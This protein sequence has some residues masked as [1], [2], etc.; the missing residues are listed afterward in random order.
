MSGR[1]QTTIVGIF[2]L[3]GIGVMCTLVFMFGGGR[4]F[5]SS[6]YD[7]NIHFDKGLV[8][9]QTG[10]GVTMYGKRIGETRAVDFW[11]PQKM[12]EGVK[13][14]VA[15]DGKYEIPALSQATVVS[16]IMGIGRPTVQIEVIDPRDAT[17]LPRDG[18]GTIMG[19]MV[20]PL[21]QVL[22][23]NMLR[24]I[25]Q[26]TEDIGALAKALQPVAQN[27]DRLLESRDIKQVDLQ[28][29]AANLDTVIQRF[30]LVLKNVNTVLGD[31]QNQANLRE[32]LANARKMSETGTAVMD[33]LKSMSEDGMVTMK[34]ADALA[35]KLISTADDMS[36]VLKRMDQTIAMLNDKQGSL[37][38]MLN[39]NRLY[40]E[41]VLSARRLTTM[42]DDMREVLDQ[43][44]QG[45]LRIK[46]F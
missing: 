39:D 29:V 45:K 43:V 9:V 21:D 11:N 3:A 42:L 7:I 37:G 17:K 20:Q 15:I 26:A 46:A 5:F 8:G 12:Q 16:N 41:M 34:D 14:V 32:M 40:E 35:R 1:R 19:E 28:Q 4:M 23:Q 33:N 10:Q 22:P 18:R 24:D 31:E 6:T 38:L 25:K 13:V 44:R 30:D 36:S 2:T 27:L